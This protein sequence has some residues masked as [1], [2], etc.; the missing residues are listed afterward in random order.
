MDLEWI[1][2][3]AERIEGE[4]ITHR[5]KLHEIAEVGFS[6]EKTSSY[7]KCELEKMGYEVQ[8]YGRCG[9]AC[10]IGDAHS[11]RQIY[12]KGEQEAFL[13]HSHSNNLDEIEI[14]KVTEKRKFFQKNKKCI[15]LRADMDAL[16]INEE[17]DLPFKSTNG[18]MHACGHD[19]H[20]AMLLGCAKILS[21]RK[22]ELPTTVK[23]M[24][25]GAEETLKGAKDMIDNGILQNPQVDFGAM[26]HVVLGANLDTGSLIFANSGVSAPS[27]DFF[28][29]T[30]LGKS[31]HG[32]MPHKSISSIP[33][34]N[35]IAL[36]LEALASTTVSASEG[37]LVTIGEIHA[38]SAPN[39]IPDKA[40]ITGSLRAFEEKS[41]D[42]LKARLKET[43]ELYSR[44]HR[45]DSVVEFT[46]GCPALVNDGELIKHGIESTT[47]AYS[48]LRSRNTPKI[49][50]ASALNSRSF[51]SEDFA[52]ISHKIPTV[53]VGICAEQKGC[54]F[55]LHHPKVEFDEDA[56]IYGAIAYSVLGLELD[57]KCHHVSDL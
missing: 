15:L 40:I 43:V 5:R 4:I 34:A 17:A 6:L 10:S 32:A 47:H 24:F 52:Y 8:K 2:K 48:F 35:H 33:P 16:P 51:A 56:L 22:N 53:M 31:S 18:N 28:K 55:P 3:E 21:K 14:K 41:R 38:G 12:G 39:I 7:V 1:V 45:T 50:D 42:E 57:K 27:S 44:A 11:S 49:I 54:S 36:A 46:S 29:I 23:L 37:A 26:L 25:Q 20:T 13:C 30:I 9:L 19:M